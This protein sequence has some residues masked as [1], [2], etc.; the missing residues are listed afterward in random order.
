MKET[1]NEPVFDRVKRLRQKQIGMIVAPGRFTRQ[2]KRGGLKQIGFGTRMK[3][4]RSI[5]KTLQTEFDEKFKIPCHDTDCVSCCH[6][7]PIVSSRIEF[8]YL[9]NAIRLDYRSGNRKHAATSLIKEWRHFCES[10]GLDPD[11]PMNHPAAMKDWTSFRIP[12]PLFVD[13]KCLLHDSRPMSCRFVKDTYAPCRVGVSHKELDTR[14][15]V[16]MPLDIALH[17]QYFDQISMYTD[18]RPEDRGISFL[19]QVNSWNLQFDEKMFPHAE[20]FRNM[21]ILDLFKALD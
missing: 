5:V 20:A 6:R 7:I 18:L 11:E 15:S 2:S 12:C 21:T 8:T 1:T 17:L 4:F 14:E 10:A 19:D 3:A 13:N 9:E 16:S